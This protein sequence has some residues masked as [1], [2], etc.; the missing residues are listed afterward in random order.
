MKIGFTCYPTKGG[1]G[2]IATELGK[3]LAER[4]HDIHFITYDLP[5]RL[6]GFQQNIFYHEV[7]VSRY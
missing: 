5:F 6:G 7:E 1:S 2:V 4:G 3:L